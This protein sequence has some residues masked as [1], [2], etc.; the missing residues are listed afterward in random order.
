M[1]V[2][3]KKRMKAKTGHEKLVLDV[4]PILILN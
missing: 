3:P 4:L 1:G 2:M